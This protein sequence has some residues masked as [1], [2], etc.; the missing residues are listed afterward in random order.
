MLVF[1]VMEKRET[2]LAGRMLGDVFGC[3]YAIIE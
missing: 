3:G 1:V 2:N